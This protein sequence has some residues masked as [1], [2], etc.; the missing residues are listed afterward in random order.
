MAR[1]VWTVDEQFAIGTDGMQFILMQKRQQK[2]GTDDEAADEPGD[3]DKPKRES[4]RES[5]YP[6]LTQLAKALV[7]ARLLVGDWENIDE[8]VRIISGM[9]DRIAAGL[10]EQL[11]ERPAEAL[12]RQR[13]LAV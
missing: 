7:T 8:A 2:K 1:R 12:E 6:N 13:H 10:V 4:W 3:S 5:Y 11:G 9:E